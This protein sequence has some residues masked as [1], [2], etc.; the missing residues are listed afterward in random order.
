MLNYRRPLIPSATIFITLV[1]H[2]RHE[3]FAASEAQTILRQAIQATRTDRPFE[4]EELVLLPD[5]LHLAITLPPEDNALSKRVAAIKARF[6]SASVAAGHAEQEQS[7]SGARQACRGVW[8]KRFWDHVVRDESDL[9][10]VREYIWYYP[11]KH[12]LA[13]CPHA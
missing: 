1:T 2:N 6:A 3:L 8:Q 4:I 11:V 7:L 13:T 10:R 12:G 9:N 5:H